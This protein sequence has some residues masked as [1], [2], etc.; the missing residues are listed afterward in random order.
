MFFEK[1]PA[2][3]AYASSGAAEA[4]SSVPVPNAVNQADGAAEQP[5]DGSAP[6]DPAGAPQPQGSTSTY[7][8]STSTTT[9][10]TPGSTP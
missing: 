2:L 8:T 5:A 9:S 3:D 1:A 4:A 6:T 7:R 10:T